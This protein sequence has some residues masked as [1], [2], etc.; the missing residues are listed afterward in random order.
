V[1]YT[2]ALLDPDDP[3]SRT[4]IG[5]ARS[6]GIP[7]HF[8]EEGEYWAPDQL[9]GERR[10]R[11]SGAVRL[12]RGY[13]EVDI[14]PAG[15]GGRESKVQVR[16]GVTT[17]GPL[18][19]LI[20][21]VVWLRFAIVLRL[22]LR[23]LERVLRGGDGRGRGDQPAAIQA[24]EALLASAVVPGLVTGR[25]RTPSAVAAT[26]AARFAGA[27]VEAGVRRRTRTWAPGGA[28]YGRWA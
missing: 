11:G 12:Q 2:Y 5:H 24:R 19:R 3:T 18:G 27:P 1:V 13:L 25:H 15:D 17:A 26:R 10:L 16:A 23:A 9:R 7:L 22:Y 6:M 14:A 20:A 8:A 21:L 28:R 4:R